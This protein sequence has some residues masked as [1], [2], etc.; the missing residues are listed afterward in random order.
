[1]ARRRAARCVRGAM[2]GGHADHPART[3][4]GLRVRPLRQRGR[5]G[6][7][8]PAQGGGRRRRAAPDP[9]GTGRQLQDLGRGMSA[10]V[11]ARRD[12][13]GAPERGR[14]P[15]E[16]PL[17]RIS[18]RLAALTVGLLCALLVVLGVTLYVTMQTAVQD[19]MRQTLQARVAGNIVFAGDQLTHGTYGPGA[20][21]PAAPGPG[22]HGPA[23]PGPGAHGPPPARPPGPLPN[24]NGTFC[25]VADAALRYV[26]SAD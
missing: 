5:R 9:H 19:T 13:R 18:W 11:R 22:A 21:G 17:R 15:D 25:V 8:A 2:P 16:A 4:L 23:A 20:H 7:P 14:A 24:T 1:M 3:R 10:A 26:T 6:H 12:T